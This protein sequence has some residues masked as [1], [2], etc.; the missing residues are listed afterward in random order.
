MESEY[1]WPLNH[2]EG[3]PDLVGPEVDFHHMFEAFNRDHDNRI[4]ML[5]VAVP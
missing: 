5:R 1:N 3:Y 4:E 2:R